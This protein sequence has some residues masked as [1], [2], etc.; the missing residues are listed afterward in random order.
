MPH[1]FAHRS[2]ARGLYLSL[3]PGLKYFYFTDFLIE[4]INSNS[5]TLKKKKLAYLSFSTI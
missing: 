4:A 1:I 5:I 3:I 2:E